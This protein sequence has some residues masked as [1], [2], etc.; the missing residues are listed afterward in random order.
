MAVREHS[1]LAEKMVE[2][3]VQPPDREEVIADAETRKRAG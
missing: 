1:M 3:L 2:L